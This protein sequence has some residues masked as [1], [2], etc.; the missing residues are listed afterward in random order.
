MKTEYNII[1]VMYLLSRQYLYKNK[2]K[3]VASGILCTFYIFEEKK[4]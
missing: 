1:Y 4:I 3:T 2:I